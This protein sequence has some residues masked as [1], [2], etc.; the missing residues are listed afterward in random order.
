MYTYAQLLHEVKRI[1]SALRGMGIAKGDRIAIYMPTMPEAI[2]L[3]LACLRIGAI[4]IVVFAGFGAGALADR[5]R[6]A[7]ARL[8]FTSDVTYRK[9]KDIPLKELV[10]AALDMRCDSVEHCIMLRRTSLESA[11]K[12]GRDLSWPDF[13]KRGD[14]QDKLARLWA[15]V[16]QHDNKPRESAEFTS[17]RAEATNLLSVETEKDLAGARPLARSLWL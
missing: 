9:G 15:G 2:M 11:A 7:G 3:M 4:H 5:I 6:S 12:P 8:L 14:G 13:L 17:H 10:D 1:A 16:K